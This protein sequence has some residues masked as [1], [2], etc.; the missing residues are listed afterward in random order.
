MSKVN[1][2]QPNETVMKIQLQLV[3]EEGEAFYLCECDAFSSS[4]IWESLTQGT[5]KNTRLQMVNQFGKIEKT[6]NI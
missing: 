2:I 4:A 5:H 6:H 3:S 1:F